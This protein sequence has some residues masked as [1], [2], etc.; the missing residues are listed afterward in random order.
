MR[1]DVLEYLARMGGGTQEEAVSEFDQL[2][3]MELYCPECGRAVPVRKSLLLV[4]PEGD[5]YV[6]CCQFCGGKVG[7]KIDRA[8]QSQGIIRP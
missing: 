4:L 6:Y 5:K 3:A 8:Q 1:K 2:E 7:D